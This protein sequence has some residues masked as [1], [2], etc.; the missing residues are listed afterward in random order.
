MGE[1]PKF[2][3]FMVVGVSSFFLTSEW[4]REISRSPKGR[5]VVAKPKK[6]RTYGDAF[7]IARR[8]DR[9]VL[10]FFW[11]ENCDWCKRM[12][13]ETLSNIDVQEVLSEYIY[14]EVNTD[15]QR[16][17]AYGKGVHNVPTYIIMDK[18]EEVINSGSGFKDVKA[19]LEWIK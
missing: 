8:T 17:I 6:P 18:N 19:F 1:K 14:I 7:K 16:D 11:S 4:G 15:T 5:L 12:K 2:L 3:W 13:E 10:V 9:K